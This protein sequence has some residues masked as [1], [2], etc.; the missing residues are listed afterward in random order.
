MT[1]ALPPDA[2]AVDEHAVE[3]DVDGYF[4]VTSVRNRESIRRYGL[5]PTRMA[6][7]PGIAGSLAPEAHGAFVARG[8]WEADWFVSMN[9]T[10]GPVDVWAVAGVDPLRL[11]DN[12]TGYLY[13][14]GT[15]AADRLT[16]VREDLPHGA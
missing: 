13:V 1:H 2:H 9:N 6:V 8:S 5:D 14:P 10:G 3:D 11:E 12:G 15:V 7:A 16:L 4:H